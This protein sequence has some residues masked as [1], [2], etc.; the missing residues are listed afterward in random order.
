MCET[1]ERCRPILSEDELEKMKADVGR[2]IAAAFEYRSD[3]EIACLLKA[4]CKDVSAFLAGEE[5][6]STEH[7]LLIHCVTRVSLDWLLTGEGARV[8]EPRNVI[9]AAEEW[10]SL[11]LA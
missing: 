6:P 5:F 2:R 9:V 10:V 8:N 1:S 4:S 11:G 3:R 7:L